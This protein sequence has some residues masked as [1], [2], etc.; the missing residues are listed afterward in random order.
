MKREDFTKKHGEEKLKEVV[1]KLKKRGFDG[2]YFST[3]EDA[4]KT[5][6][7]I[8]PQDA[9]VGVGGSITIRELG[10]LPKLKERGHEV[11]D[12][13][14]A[15][16][17]EKGKTTKAQPTSN[18]F[19][20]SSNAIT[21]KGQLVNIDGAGNRVSSMIFGPDKV[22]IFAG[23]NKIVN[24]LERAIWHVKNYSAVLNFKRLSPEPAPPCTKTGKC[25]DCNFPARLCRVTA[26]IDAPPKGIKEYYVFL[27]NEE[28]GF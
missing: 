21:E 22:I 19:I 12:H 28:L 16:P 3:M 24:D 5:A 15:P 23:V 7:D 14:S 10:I 18:V 17:A 6:L 1:E 8:I 20:S 9:T 11:F 27:I 13:W 2:R 25:S 26:I 4:V